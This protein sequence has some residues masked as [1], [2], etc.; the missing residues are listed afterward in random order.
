VDENLTGA[1]RIDPNQSL[2]ETCMTRVRVNNVLLEL[3]KPARS[4]H[5]QKAIHFSVDISP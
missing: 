2:N 5:A 3:G 4:W 1:E